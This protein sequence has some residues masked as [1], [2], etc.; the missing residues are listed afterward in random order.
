MCKKIYFK[1]L[2]T[3][4]SVHIRLVALLQGSWVSL[5]ASIYMHPGASIEIG[6][7]VRIGNGCVLSILPSATLELNDGCK[8]NSGVF[9][10]CASHIKIGRGVRVAHYSSILDHDYDI[11]ADGNYFDL[12]KVSMPI[13]IGN[14]VWLGAY[15]LI[16]KGVSIGNNSVI[17]AQTMVRKSVPG[18]VLAYCHSNGQ[19]IFKELK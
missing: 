19:L 1:F 16:F 12:P 3:L 9:I 6:K 5:G 15:S 4:N 11:H 10:Y 17:G 2:I 18:G 13:I 14:G 7:G 8:I